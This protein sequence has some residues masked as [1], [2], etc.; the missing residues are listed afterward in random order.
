MRTHGG[1]DR[2]LESGDLQVDVAFLAAPA[3]DPYG[4]LNAV[5]GPSAFGSFGYAFADARYARCV[6]ALTDNLMPYPLARVSIDQTLVDYVVEVHDI[7]S[8]A[9]I[10]SGTTKI[11]RDPVGRRIA[12]LT[13]EAIA[14]SEYFK[15]GFS[16]QTGAGGISLAAAMYVREKMLS[17]GVS[18]S[19]GLGGITTPM[20]EMLQDGCFQMLLDTQCFDLGAVESIRTNPRHREISCSTYSNPHS[21]GAAVNMLDAVVLGA[22][23]IDL[24]FNVN[25]TTGCDGVIMGG[26]GGHADAAAGSKLCVIVANLFRRR[27]PTI[28]ESVTTVNTP[29]ETVD[30]LVTEFGMAV[31][32][33]RADMRERLLDAGLPLLSIEEL[34]QRAEDLCGRPEALRVSDRVVAAVEYRDGT[35]IDVIRQVED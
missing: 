18:G 31:N 5:D 1:R 14:V 9:G 28:V 15:D 32:P 34:K 11:T 22:T 4:N 17:R 10:L 25:V 21:K 30:L 3:A 35:V 6:I 29:G 2:A 24:D 7:G 16:F 26:S 20:V 12:A 13:A 27:F 8:A 33:R 19:F 23:E